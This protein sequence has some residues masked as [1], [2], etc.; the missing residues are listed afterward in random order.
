[1]WRPHLPASLLAQRGHVT[2]RDQWDVSGRDIHGSGLRQTTLF[3][4]WPFSVPQRLECRRGGSAA[5]T[6]R[7]VDWERGR[8]AT[9]QKGPGLWVTSWAW[10]T[11]LQQPGLRPLDWQV[12]DG[13]LPYVSCW[14]LYPQRTCCMVHPPYKRAPGGGVWPYPEPVSQA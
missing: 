12:R 9:E 8:A 5:S 1:M 4:C 2:A 11:P 3:G 6:M 10:S 7:D 13:L 14:F